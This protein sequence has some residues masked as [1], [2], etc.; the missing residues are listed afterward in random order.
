MP[1]TIIPLLVI[2]SLA[3]GYFLRHA[4]THPTTSV[5][6]NASGASIL[7][8]EVE[9]LKCKGT[10]AFFTSL[11]ENVPGINSIETFASEHRAVFTYD[12]ASITPEK[13]QE[14]IEQPVPLRDGS[15]VQVFRCLSMK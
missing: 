6:F 5:A 11:F 14:I 1:K 2:A 10:A 8:C 7:T 15:E 13:I 3:G 12:P 9:G 4:F